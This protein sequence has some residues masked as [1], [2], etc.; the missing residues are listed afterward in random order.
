MASSATVVQLL[1]RCFHFYAFH[2]FPRD[3]T[4]SSIYWADFQRAVI[5]LAGQGT[6]LLGTQEQGEYFWRSDDYFFRK[7]DFKR[8]FRSISFP[9]DTSKQLAQTDYDPASILD[10]IMDVLATTQP[11]YV[12]MLPSH[13]QLESVA[14][15]LFGEAST[16]TR[17]QSSRKDLSILLGLILRL[18]LCKTTR[19]QRFPIGT[20]DKADPGDNEL[21]KIL[22][23]GL[24]GNQAE[25][26]LTPEQIL[27]AVDLLVS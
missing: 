11:Q 6:D 4:N 14:Q 25:E 7:A 13:D 23:S 21:A 16:Q 19:R 8:I 3:S 5:L 2:P 15:K 24:A 22:I 9:K 26:F 10:D 17:Y 20:F 18:R 1:W 12:C 27:R